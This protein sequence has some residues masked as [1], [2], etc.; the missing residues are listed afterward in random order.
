M[1]AIKRLAFQAV[2]RP[3]IIQNYRRR[4]EGVLPDE[5]YWADE[6]ALSWGYAVA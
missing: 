5:W 6:L 3:L 1:A 2:L 4:A